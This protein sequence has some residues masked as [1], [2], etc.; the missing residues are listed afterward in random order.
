MNAA[1]VLAYGP[2]VWAAFGGAFVLLAVETLTVWRTGRK[3]ADERRAPPRRAASSLRAV[4]S[5][6]LGEHR[7][8][9]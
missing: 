6:P 7:R 9:G 3:T 1:P 4:S 8:E 2:F 5:S